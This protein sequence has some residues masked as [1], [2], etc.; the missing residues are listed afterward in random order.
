MMMK[1]LKIILGICL[2]LT[3]DSCKDVLDENPQTFVSPANF[4]KSEKDFD[5]ALKG[6]YV[7]VRN[8]YADFREVELKET[9]AEYIGEPESAEQTG[10]MW[11]NNPGPNFWSIRYG[12]QFPY[13]VIS[14]TNLILNQL[15]GVDF[16]PNTMDEIE[17]EA[18]FLRAFAYFDL[19]QLYGDVPL[20]TEPV[21]TLNEVQIERAPQADVYTLIME[22]LKIAEEKLPVE[23]KQ[24]GRVYQLA[25]TAMLARVYLV[26]AGNPMNMTENYAKAKDKAVSVIN[27]GKFNLLADYASVFHNPSYTS[28]SIWEILVSPPIVTNSWH[29]MSAP[30]GNQTA[31]FIPTTD[32]MNSFPNGD[33]RR[34]WGIKSSYTNSVGD[35]VIARPYFNKYINESFLE[36]GLAPSS[37]NSLLDYTIPIIRLAEMYLI[38]AEAENEMNGPAGAYQY[39]NEIRRRARIDKNDPTQVPDLSVL[40]KEKFREAVFN[41]RR[42]EL[43]GEYF[44]WFDLKRT[45]N[46][47][48][49]EQARGNALVN[50]IGSYNQTW[51]LPDFELLNNQIDDN[52]AYN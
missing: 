16:L 3:T 19:V 26:T 40:T 52:P 34:E 10:D 39:I 23:P 11:R 20:R 41:E 5:A 27:S 22:D 47:Q 37:A 46:F 1:L 35:V 9:F 42:W 12:W 18:R 13:Q 2:L 36:Q 50:P 44:G 4:F 32:F 21:N 15:E 25:A 24:L 14:N 29:S 33:R 30:T 7:S 6:V 8:M 45:N 28:E 49:V 31:I 51:I 48:K 17:G 43:H 38:A